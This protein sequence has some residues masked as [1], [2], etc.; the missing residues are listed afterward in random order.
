VR[1]KAKERQS[2]SGPTEGRGKKKSGSGNVPEPV[3]GQS[4]DLIGARVGWSG[5]T[6]EKAKMVVEA[7]PEASFL[8]QKC[9]T[10]WPWHTLEAE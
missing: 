4:R 8:P 9:R 2:E 6:Y 5:K 7:A 10:F 1:S 3:T